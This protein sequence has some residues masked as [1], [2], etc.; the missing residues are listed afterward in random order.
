MSWPVWLGVGAL[1]G[2]GALA[3]FVFDGLVSARTRGRFP[4]G[5]FVV[6][7]SGGFVLGLLAGLEVTGNEEILLGTATIGSY[8]TF[9]TWMLETDR[10]VEDGQ[11]TAAVINIVLG[12]CVGLAAAEVGRLL[13]GAL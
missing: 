13:G 3:R 12:L 7:I 1:G 9:S 4:W 11:A 6:N 2:A 8:T 10:S 5:T